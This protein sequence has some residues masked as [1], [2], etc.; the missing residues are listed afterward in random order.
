MAAQAEV[1]NH[2]P[3]GSKVLLTMG[4]LTH[5]EK[6][7]VQKHGHL[8]RFE[9]QILKPLAYEARRAR[10]SVRRLF[11]HQMPRATQIKH[12]KTQHLSGGIVFGR[13][14]IRP[15]SHS[16]RNTLGK[17]WDI[18]QATRGMAAYTCCTTAYHLSYDDTFAEDGK[19]K[20]EKKLLDDPKCTDTPSEFSYGLMFQSIVRLLH[21]LK[22]TDCMKSI[23]N[24]WTKVAFDGVDPVVVCT[25]TSKSEQHEADRLFL[26]MF[27][28]DKVVSST[29][30]LLHI[31]SP[32]NESDDDLWVEPAFDSI[33]HSRLLVPNVPS[34]SHCSSLRAAGT[35]SRV[36][37]PTI[38]EPQCLSAAVPPLPSV[39][40]M[41]S[42]LS[43]LPVVSGRST[44]SVWT[45]RS[46]RTTAIE[47]PLDFEYAGEGEGEGDDEITE[48]EPVRKTRARGAK[49]RGKNSELGSVVAPTAAKRR[50]DKRK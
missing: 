25:T 47:V 46:S 36:P 6:L 26:E 44:T 21:E 29:I 12:S 45:A 39:D 10:S 28:A 32:D 20:W 34:I 37:S 4:K 48:P 33:S 31:D 16:K 42:A 9:R 27:R 13:T 23:L 11:S 50:R 17:L 41:S 3:K 8:G 18:F 24:F 2:F 35:I 19:G 43:A 7:S 14:A 38:L 15:S 49:M 5:V 40:F 1:H 22:A 30:P